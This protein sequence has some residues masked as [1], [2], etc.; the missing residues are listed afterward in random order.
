MS[1]YCP[2]VL[3]QDQNPRLYQVY[4]RE[5]K[6]LP[7]NPFIYIYINRINNKLVFKIKDGYKLDPQNSETMILFSS[8]K[9]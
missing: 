9:K 2:M 8:T 3:I 4:H 5:H 6:K 7:T 1:L